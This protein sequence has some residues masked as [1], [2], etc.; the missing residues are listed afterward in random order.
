MRLWYT[1]EAFD[2]EEALPVGN[3]RLGGM[4]YGDPNCE[5]ILLNEDTLWSG[6]PVDKNRKSSR[7]HLNGV[8]NLLFEKQFDK[9]HQL[10]KKEMLGQPTQ[11]Y[12]PMGSIDM[13]YNHSGDIM[14]YERELSLSDSICTSGFQVDGTNYS[15]EVFASNPDQCIVIKI[16][17]DK[18]KMLNLELGLSS[19]LKHSITTESDNTI[20]LKGRCPDHIVPSFLESDNPVVYEEEVSSKSIRYMMKL[21]IFVEDGEC[22]AGNNKIIVSN[23]KSLTA[24]FVAE[25]SFVKFNCLPDKSLEKMN[26]SLDDLLEKLSRTG[27][28]ILKSRHI[29]DYKALFDRVNLSIGNTDEDA[30]PTNIRLNNYQNGSK[31][32]QLIALL[33]HYGRYLLI[34]CSREGSQPANLQGIWNHHLRAPWCSNY[35]TNI[36]LEMNYWPTEVCNLSELHTPLFQFIEE[37]SQTGAITARTNYGCNGWVAHHMTDLWRS[38]SPVGGTPSGVENTSEDPVSYAMWPLAGAWLCCHLWERY[39]YT[40]D[41]SFLERTAFPLIEGSVRFF[42][43]YLVEDEQS[44]YVTNPSTSPENEFV[45]EG[46][47]YSA[48]ISSTMDIALLRE[49]FT[50]YIEANKILGNDG[51]M[52]TC[53]VK[54]LSK[55]RPYKVGENGA[56]LEWNEP[57]EESNPLHRHISHLYGL[58]PGK[59]L[60]ENHLTDAARES[61]LLKGEDSTGWSLAWRVNLFARLKDGRNALKMINKML[62][63]VSETQ[64][65][66]SLAGGIYPNLMDAHPPFEIDGNFGVTSGIAEMLMQSHEGVIEILPAIP[67]EWDKGAVS[68][69]KARGNIEVAI[70][71][72]ENGLVKVSLRSL[73]DRVVEIKFAQKSFKLSLCGGEATVISLEGH[74]ENVNL[75]RHK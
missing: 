6:Y 57:F 44:N 45:F 46:K 51:T 67:R 18:E 7:E 39:L 20:V 2:W 50:A 1:R 48:Y 49:L 28:E 38:T 35:T 55:L 24:V 32:N 63:L 62:T 27:Y 17:C 14:T 72:A 37:I 65:D 74:N 60:I 3:G 10:I 47:D 54:A 40:L 53:T 58:Y 70:Q 4:V 36:N 21:N 69:L 59:S 25:T 9:A 64:I 31:D 43:D 23:A 68:G 41:E 30:V 11:S 5:K 19:I 71:W 73:R 42:L 29:K 12:L 56:L 8:R 75:Y 33:F 22:Y 26:Q 61:L 13:K 66:Y 52:H 34:S 15:Q 16:S